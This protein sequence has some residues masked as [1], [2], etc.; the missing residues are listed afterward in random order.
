MKRQLPVRFWLEVGLAS[1]TGI[2]FLVTLIW[3]DW[4]EIVF[5][6]EPDAGSGMLEWLI[7]GILLMATIALFSMAGYEW[8]KT[9]A[10][11]G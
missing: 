2:L 10:A 6:V 5:G 7:V 9:Q 11:Q 3:K 1:V 8:R 4:I